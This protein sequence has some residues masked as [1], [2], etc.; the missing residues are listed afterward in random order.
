MKKYILISLVALL[1]VAAL[2]LIYFLVPQTPLLLRAYEAGNK[3]PLET[4]N[5]FDA[6]DF[7]LYTKGDTTVKLSSELQARMIAELDRLLLELNGVMLLNDHQV[8][9]VDE[10]ILSMKEEGT[11][12]FC[13]LQRRRFTG[14][15]F[16]H[17]MFK[18]IMEGEPLKEDE[19]YLTQVSFREYFWE[20]L[21][22]DEIIFRRCEVFFGVDGRYKNPGEYQSVSGSYFIKTGEITYSD[23]TFTHGDDDLTLYFCKDNKQS[24]F[25]RSMVDIAEAGIA[26]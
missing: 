18:H 23:Q 13:Y 9:T 11:I 7:I 1:L 6:P 16:E 17:A 8:F 10:Q 26:G 20:D 19:R 25:F 12:R 24:I 3:T 4:E 14:K 5:L 21:Q 15:L 2:L 22:Y